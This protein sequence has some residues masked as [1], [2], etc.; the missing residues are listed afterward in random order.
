M[1]EDDEC[2]I[3]FLVHQ[4]QAGAIIGRGGSRVK[5]IREVCDDSSTLDAFIS[6]ITVKFL[7]LSL[8]L[9]L[10]EAIAS[11]AVFVIVSGSDRVTETFLEPA[12]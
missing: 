8:F 10:D 7:A 3:R 6:Y 9:P 1:S 12:K 11:R 5:V 2:E 4:S